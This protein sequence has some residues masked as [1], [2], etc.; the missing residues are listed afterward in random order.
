MLDSTIFILFIVTILFS[1]P[2]LLYS[3]GFRR[4]IKL[5][6]LNGLELKD[7]EK[8]MRKLPLRKK[9]FMTY[10]W[11]CNS[12][13]KQSLGI[14]TWLLVCFYINMIAYLVFL[15]MI[16]SELFAYQSVGGT[17]FTLVLSILIGTFPVSL[18]IAIPFMLRSK[19]LKQLTSVYLPLTK[20]ERTW[21]K[22]FELILDNLP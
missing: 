13:G 6:A 4:L 17:T 22:I 14:A 5:T 18:I 16:L 9:L 21:E 19:N 7:Y 12:T 3:A 11:R 15:I 2:P 20:W 1:I 8:L 10:I